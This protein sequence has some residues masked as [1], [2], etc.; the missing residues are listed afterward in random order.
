MKVLTIGDLHG[1][2]VW[3]Q[4]DFSAYDQ[5]IFIGDYID[6]PS[7]EEDLENLNS[8]IELKK[9]NPS[10]IKLLL[11]N[12]DLQYFWYPNQQM[13]KYK[14]S[15]AFEFFQIFKE[16][17]SLFDICFQELDFIW[18]HAGISNSWINFIQEKDADLSGLIHSNN[19]CDVINNLFLE[20]R[21][22][23]LCSTGKAKG[24]AQIGGPIRADISEL[25]TDF[26]RGVFQIA[27]HNRTKEIE[28]YGTTKSG[29][30]FC[31]CLNSKLEFLELDTNTRLI[32]ILHVT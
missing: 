23:L 21:W 13:K 9:S 25:R 28:Q 12:H 14:E 24:G 5:I 10:K 15:L 32:H 30:V 22:S 31:D 6:G 2:Q 18:T 11:G 17:H 26:M 4:L 27:G 20:H 19:V 8:I 29:I 7:D 3:K 1:K 16:N